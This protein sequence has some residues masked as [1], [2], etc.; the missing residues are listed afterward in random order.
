MTL[1]A[2]RGVQSS[3]WHEAAASDTVQQVTKFR[4]DIIALDSS[5]PSSLYLESC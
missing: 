3:Y 1:C 5:G 2:T 4:T